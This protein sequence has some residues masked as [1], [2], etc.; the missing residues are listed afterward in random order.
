MLAGAGL[1]AA[2]VAVLAGAIT[3]LYIDSREE[4]RR[5]HRF[6]DK[7]A[8]EYKLGRRLGKYVVGA[9]A[10]PGP[11]TDSCYPAPRLTPGPGPRRPAGAARA[12]FM[13]LWIAPRAGVSP[14][15]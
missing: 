10:A 2:A 11:V 8:R 1:T 12:M 6:P 4:H 9:A 15:K 5:A 13:P 14:S 3:Y 7:L